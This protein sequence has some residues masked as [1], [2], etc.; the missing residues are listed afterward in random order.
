[1]NDFLVEVVPAEVGV[2][3]GGFHFEDTVADFE[4]GDVEGSAPEVVHGDVFF[5]LSVQAVRQ[6]GGGGLVDDAEHFQTGDFAGVLGGL[7]LTV[8]EISGNGDHRL[9]D[10]FTEV[11]FR[12]LF[13]LLQNHRGNFRRRVGFAGGFDLHV[14][15]G[16]LADLVGHVFQLLADFVVAAAHKAFHGGDGV[17]GVGDR[18]AF[19]GLTDQPLAVLGE[20]DNRGRGPRALGV[21]DYHRLA[22]FHDGHTTVCG[23]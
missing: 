9:G 13:Q 12:V 3:V 5:G 1:M 22:A 6:R 16:G 18:L 14:A 23:S 8:I 21:R 2:A 11:G 15:V 20:C 19:G 7:T 10:F 4:H 17:Q